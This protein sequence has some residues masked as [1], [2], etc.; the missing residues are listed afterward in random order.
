MDTFLDLSSQITVGAITAVIA[1]YI[2]VRLSLRRF[3]S[4]KWWE[5]KAEAY[6]AILEALHYM[7]RSFDEDLE[8]DMLRREIPEDRKEQLRQKYREADDE[9]KKRIDIGQFVLSDEA[10]LT[11]GELRKLNALKK[12]VGDK[13]GEKAFVQWLRNKNESATAVPRDRNAEIIAD[14]LGKLVQDGGLKLPRGGYLVTRG[15][16]RVVVTRAKS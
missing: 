16:G 11:K 1:S 5:K 2:T 12:S 4:E 14:T 10:A 15:R 3:Y 9:L 8:A 7:K 13:I 6:S